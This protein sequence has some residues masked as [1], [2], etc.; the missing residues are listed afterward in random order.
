MITLKDY[1]GRHAQSA[2]SELN[3]AIVVNANALL[4]RVN[5]L[6]AEIAK[7]GILPGIN[8][9]TGNAI[10]SG[11]R[12]PSYNAKV[13]NAA[14]KSKHMTGHAVDL[15]DPEGDLDDY[16]NHNLHLLKQFGLYIEHPAATKNW[17]HLQSVAP[18]SGNRVFYP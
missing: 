13:A 18:K 16:L 6:L 4:D 5:K 14:A 17:C 12:P 10:S 15:Y 3:D 11:W 7:L 2:A 8:P 1:L 9:E